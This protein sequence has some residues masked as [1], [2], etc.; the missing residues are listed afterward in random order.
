MNYLAHILLS[1]SDDHL[2]IGNFAGDFVKGKRWGQLPEKVGQGVLLHRF[3]DSFA[4]AHEVSMG[5]KKSLH[6]VIGKWAGVALDVLYDHMLAKHWRQYGVGDLDQFSRS[7]YQRMQ[8]QQHLIPQ[9]ALP[10]LEA[11]SGTNWLL[12]YADFETIPRVF[13]AMERRIGGNANLYPAAAT[14]LDYEE[15][16][17]SGFATFFPDL[18]R[19]CSEKISI[20][21]RINQT[22]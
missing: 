16:F 12:S 5:L 9:K 4:D 10:L 20:F 15:V 7:A 21:E 17:L 18:Q 3:I 8:K 2:L 19:A 14:Y 6:P 11:M 22:S 13:A 1:G